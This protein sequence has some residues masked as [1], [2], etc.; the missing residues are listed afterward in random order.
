MKKIIVCADHEIG[1]Q[2]INYI[3][4]ENSNHFEILD[5]YTTETNENGFWRPLKDIP[6]LKKYK[7]FQNN[8]CFL[9]DID[10]KNIDYIFLISW[11]YIFSDEI[12]KKINFGIINLHYSLLPNYPGV[13]PVNNAIIS[14]EKITGITF[15][16]IDELID[17]GYLLHQ[18]SINIKLTDTVDSLLA[19]LDRLSLKEFKKIWVGKIKLTKKKK[20]SN[21][22]QKNYTHKQ[23]EYS[24]KLDPHKKYTALELVNL[25]RGKTFKNHKYL[26]LETTDNKKFF[27]SIKVS[28]GKEV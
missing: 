23:F 7:I 8:H 14:G 2:I 20:L 11:K 19:R 24:N 22:M 13:Y 9:G 10:Q 25:I 21:K 28:E 5:I 1:Y 18:K 4:S 26:Y 17:K 15:H 16:F 12:I 6:N 27:I 3:L